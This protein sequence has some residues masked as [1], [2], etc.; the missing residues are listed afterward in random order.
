MKSKLSLLLAGCL[1]AGSLWADLPF[2]N[3]R[4][5][6]FRV[7]PVNNQSIVFMGNSITQGNEWSETYANDPRVLNRG[8]SGNTSAEILN[9][10]DY[11][12]G[13]KPAKIF[14]MIGINDGADPEIVVPAIRK[15]IELT[16]K[17]SP[18]T[19]IYIQSILPY[20]GR[21]N[22][23]TTNNLLKKLC[24]EKGVTYVDVYA[25]LGGTDT[26]LSLSSADSN[27]GL[28]LLGSGYR[29][30]VTG[31]GAL[32]GIEPVL[33]VAGNVTIPS[34]HANYVN[35]RVS[36]FALMP[37]TETDILMLGDF[38]VNTAEWRE[39][40][41]NPRVKNRGIGVNHGGTSISLPE[42]KE[43][44]P[45]IVKNNPA[46]VFISCGY[47][48]L[49]YNGKT[50]EQVLVSYNEV[51]TAI[52]NASPLTAIYMQS[53]V[54]SSNATTNS[55]KY[56]PFNAGIQN[57]ASDENK[58]Y[59]VDVY[60]ALQN[61]GVLNSAYA[62]GNGGLNAKGYLKWVEI[63]A[64]YVDAT[65]KP[66]SVASYDLQMALATA[67]Q[68]LYGMKAENTAGSYSKELIDA[69]RTAIDNAAVVAGNADATETAYTE[70][71]GSLNAAIAAV[72]QS[73]ML[74]PLLSNATNEYWYK[75]SAPLRSAKYVTG[76]GAGLI[77]I[78]ENNY[79]PQQWKFTLR[80]DNSWNI[81]NRA[82][83]S[84]IN[85]AA[86]NNT[87]IM[88]SATE[89]VNGWT[90]KPAAGFSRFII[91]SNTAQLNQTSIGNS[92]V[93]NWGGGNNVNDDGCQFL[94]TEVT[95]EPDEEPVVSA[96][97]PFLRL[98]DIVCT[99]A[100]PVAVN[101]A[102]AAAVF[103]R[104]TL[105]VAIDF[106]PSVT[107]GDAMLIASSNIAD[108]NKFFGI[109]TL[110][111]FTKTGVRY[112]G[113]NSLEGWYS[114]GYSPAAARHRLVITMSPG[115]SNYNYYIDEA[116]LRNVSGMGAY[117]YYSFGKIPNA[118]LYLGGVVSLNAPNRYPFQGTIHSVQFFD[119]VLS[120]D[121]VKRI[122][123][124]NLSSALH[125]SRNADDVPF[126]V[127]N[128]TI[129]AKP[130]LLIDV[131]DIAGRKLQNTQLQTG[132][133]IVVASGSSYKVRLM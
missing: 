12:L 107:T 45:H 44:I 34:S 7:L 21:I 4:R 10:L 126:T 57:L 82:D 27:D 131:Y 97:Q 1:F 31:S 22:V 98:S 14:L 52:R 54:P 49:E 32:T 80:A 19:E 79:R 42:L 37:V 81:V 66:L 77:S 30:W 62:W 9:N 104:D 36:A 47:K 132:Y 102:D 129:V 25:R 40:L 58:I 67:R 130:G 39:L 69:L 16:Q 61:N 68:H 28:H 24:A 109:G 78:A 51:I 48:D 35:Q 91:T 3:Q 76:T 88:T 53:L 71:L 46:K 105:T 123:Y 70:A 113:D 5:D 23:L 112:V 8:I 13:G 26:N 72:R 83:G 15:S 89:P 11:V 92:M 127:H 73:A 122:D 74:L 111:N 121:E 118:V 114:S 116:F 96:P 110:T 133:Y 103:E 119:G 63:L 64:P 106:T 125:N 65:I 95:G 86:A 124:S 85:P 93:Y 55:T 2:R 60:Q 87:Q 99:G 117:G 90:L 56:A 108:A 6:M 120:A 17:E 38:H 18:A 33:P 128:R 50:V 101:T 84:F 43:M 20:G 29:K 100:A 41:R 59:F 115:V 75:L 94:I